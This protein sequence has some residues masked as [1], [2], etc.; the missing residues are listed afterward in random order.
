MSVKPQ[1]S[2]ANVRGFYDRNFKT[3]ISY[4]NWMVAI[5]ATA[6]VKTLIMGPRGQTE[7]DVFLVLPTK[8][9][10]YS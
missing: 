6:V 1:T 10:D 2:H 8:A 7:E 3:W 4:F 9:L 5:A